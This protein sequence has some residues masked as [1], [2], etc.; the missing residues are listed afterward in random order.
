M[1]QT[2]RGILAAAGGFAASIAS[3]AFAGWE[4]AQRYPDSAVEI[5]DP[6][7]ARYRLGLAFLERVA[8]RFRWAEGP[9]WFCDMHVLLFSDAS[10]DRIMSWNEQTG[11]VGTFRKPSNYANG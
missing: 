8:T 5:L 3:D 1:P 2:R 11:E 9:V 10:N 7:F 6:S 4:P